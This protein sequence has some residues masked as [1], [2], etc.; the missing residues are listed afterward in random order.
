[1]DANELVTVEVMAAQQNLQKGTLDFIFL[2]K[3][4][5]CDKKYK[6]TT[7]KSQIEMRIGN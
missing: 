1:M 3:K 6:T 4:I 2:R 5:N 7:I